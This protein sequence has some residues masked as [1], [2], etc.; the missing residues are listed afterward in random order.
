MSTRRHQ[1]SVRLIIY[2]VYCMRH[3]TVN[4]LDFFLKN[5][6]GQ[7]VHFKLMNCTRNGGWTNWSNW[8]S[9]EQRITQRRRR[10]CENPAPVLRIRHCFGKECSGCGIDYGSCERRCVN[11]RCNRFGN[12]ILVHHFSQH[13]LNRQKDKLSKQVTTKIPANWSKWEIRP[14]VAFRYRVPTNYISN[15]ALVDIQHQLIV[16]QSPTHVTL[17][18]CLYVSILMMTLGFLAQCL[19]SKLFD[20]CH[21]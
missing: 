8:S 5:D 20:F 6:K 19:I 9:C 15:H 4:T 2:E 3:N 17:S 7:R 11:E 1:I 16:H 14:G 13:I 10:R 18:F 21:H 12:R